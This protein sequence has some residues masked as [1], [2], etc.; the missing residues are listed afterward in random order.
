VSESKQINAS[1]EAAII[2]AGSGMLS[3]GRIL[4][5]LMAHAGDPDTT[6]MIVGYQP[7]GGLGRR[8]IDGE[9]SVRIMGREVTVRA[10]TV[11][12]GGLSAHADR[13]ELLDWVRPSAPAE[14]RLIHGEPSAMNHLQRTLAGLGRTATLQP[15]DVRLPE[16]DH[17]DEAGE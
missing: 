3:G 1:D 4:H 11:T 5:H 7:S 6:V 12:V 10:R 2:I 15:S 17:H 8:L 14:I 9:R 13:T 16:A